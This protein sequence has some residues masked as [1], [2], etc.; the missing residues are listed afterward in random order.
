MSDEIIHAFS[1]ALEQGSVT[2]LDFFTPDAVYHD[3]IHGEFHGREALNGF[4]RRWEKDG[5]GYVWRFFDVMAD[6]TQGY[7]RWYFAY[8]R[9]RGIP[10]KRKPEG[11][12]LELCGMSHFR[13]RAGR[14]AEYRETLNPG[15]SLLEMGLSAPTLIRQLER[16]AAREQAETVAVRERLGLPDPRV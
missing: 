5:Q 16:H 1:A 13:F 2:A 4:F 6:A 7:A 10:R 8:R 12:F 11:V 14:I 15:T 9:L 3:F